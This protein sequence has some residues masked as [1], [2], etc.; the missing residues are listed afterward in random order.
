MSSSYPEAARS[1]AAALA[2]LSSPRGPGHRD[3]H[4]QLLDRAIVEGELAVAETDAAGEEAGEHGARARDV[5][6][7]AYAARAADALHGANQLS[8]S[9]QR[10]PTPE[11]CD[12]GWQRVASLV[13]IAEQAA[14][15]SGAD[16]DGIRRAARRLLDERNHAYTFH[17]DPGFSFG[18]GW[19]V[20]AAAVLAGVSVQIEPDKPGTAA[21]ERFLHEAGLEAQV[22]P[23]GP[24]P[25]AN[26]QTTDCVARAFR[27]DPAGAQRR[28]RA[29]FL[30]DAPVAEAVREWIDRRLSGLGGGPKVLLWVRHGAHH[31]RR[32]TSGT[33]LVELSR[34]AMQHGLTPVLVG[35]ALRDVAVPDGTVDLLLFWKDAVF[36]GAGGRRAQLQ[37]FEHLRAAHGVVGQIGVTTAGMDGPALMGMPTAYLTDAPNPRMGAWVGA[38]PG[39]REIVRDCRS[40]DRV[41]VALTEWLQPVAGL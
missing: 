15:A 19:Y 39:Y 10:A 34:L 36:G 1:L 31:A 26:K 35:D 5:L 17:T 4:R 41:S 6:A 30:G 29:A 11:A 16:A 38:V 22:R 28:L 27:A 33:E 8:L 13:A 40:Q 37:F 2:A 24:R 20:A 25:R 32:N 3:R 21:A 18:E 23:F 7:R 9:A 12:E 14:R